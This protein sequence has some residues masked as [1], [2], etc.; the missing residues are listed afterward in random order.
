MTHVLL[1][2]A[3]ADRRRWLIGWSTGIVLT[4]VLSIAFWPSMEG[5]ADEMNEMIE[6]MPESL[7]ALFGMGEGIDPFSPI[8]YLSAQVY[9]LTLPVLLLIAGIGLAGALAG[10]EERGLL[11]VTWTLPIRRWQVVLERWLAVMALTTALAAVTFVS[12]LA[13]TRAVGLEVGVGSLVWATFGALALTWAVSAV[14]LAAGA[15]TGR[16]GLAISVASTIAVASY[17]V[18]SLADA[19]IGFFETLDVVSVFTYYDVVDT[20]VSGTPS[21]SLLVLLGAAAVMVAL[22]LRSIEG[23]DL[24]SS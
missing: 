14:C 18:T 12:T 23:R 17:L 19:R 10:D 9:A 22:A 13:S 3:M 24:R 11:E 15:R 6:E 21:W 5:Q 2:R 8:G 16:R 20:L 7:R 1:D 4:I